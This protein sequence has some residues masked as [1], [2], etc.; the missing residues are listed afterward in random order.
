MKDK[1]FIF[2]LDDTLVYELDYLKSAYKEIALSLEDEKLFYQMLEWYHDGAD[3]F[4]MVAKTF[5]ISKEKLLQFYRMHFPTLV[6]NDGAAEVLTQI[7]SRGHFLGL[8][9]DGRSITQ[10]NKLKSLG[11]ESLFDKI[12]IS[13][14][15]GTTKPN[16]TNYEV[17]VQHD[18]IEYFYIGDNVK[19]DFV[20]PNKL[21]WTTVCLK[22]NGSN[23][24]PQSFDYPREQLP[25]HIINNML[26]LK[27]FI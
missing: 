24:H 10:R 25:K 20:T 3:V 18:I 16:S 1:Y 8:I 4:A 19:K 9:T 17:F 12:I 14:E 6:L 22:D 15:F 21:G 7:K 2:D 5:P 11:I 13:E 27:N 23:I 26:D